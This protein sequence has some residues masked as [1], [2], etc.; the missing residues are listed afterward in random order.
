MGICFSNKDEE[1]LNEKINILK[2]IKFILLI[3]KIKIF[4]FFVMEK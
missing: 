4:F 2:I 3:N 1:I